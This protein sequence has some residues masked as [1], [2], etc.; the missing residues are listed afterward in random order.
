MTFSQERMEPRIT[1]L[2]LLCPK[3]RW[4]NPLSVSRNIKKQSNLRQPQNSLVYLNLVV[5]KTSRALIKNLFS[6]IID[7][8]RLWA[9]DTQRDRASLK[10]RM[11]G[12]KGG[13]SRSISLKSTLNS[14]A[15]YNRCNRTWRRCQR[16]LVPTSAWQEVIIRW[17]L[18]KGRATHRYRDQCSYQAHKKNNWTKH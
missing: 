2:P 16:R 4:S 7:A 8:S 12:V 14:K 5:L 11:I 15:L 10:M 18:D 6:M 17:Q 3:T 1:K 9:L 13:A